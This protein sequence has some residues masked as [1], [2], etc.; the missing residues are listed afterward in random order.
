[1]F[2][3]P[4]EARKRSPRRMNTAWLERAF[5]DDAGAFVEEQASVGMRV[6]NSRKESIIAGRSFILLQNRFLFAS[7]TLHAGEA[8][9]V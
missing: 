2:F 4:G 9:L 7:R 3:S 6:W 1:M 5:Q 8:I